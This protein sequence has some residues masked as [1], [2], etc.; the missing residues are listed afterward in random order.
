MAN[1]IVVPFLG[2]LQAA[3]TVLLTI[4]AGVLAAQMGL[5]NEQTSKQI[6][7]V[8]VQ[9]FLP[10]LL[11]SN[12][13]S[14]MHADTALYYVPIIIWAIVYNAVSILFG[15]AVQRLFKLPEWA[16]PAIAFN[17]TTALPLLLVQALD[18]TGILDSI[19]ASSGVV[20]RAKSF[21]LVNAMIG[22][23]LTFALGPKLLSGQN[24][25]APDGEGEGKFPTES[26]DDAIDRR[27][28]EQE[29][30]AVETNEQTSLLPGRIIR[31]L[32][33]AGYAGYGKSK[34]AWV[35]LPPWVQATLDFSSQ[36]FNAPLIG[37]AIGV[38]I[39][40]VPS[41]HR[42]FF[43]VGVKLSSSLLKMKK[44]EAGG[45]VPWS[46]IFVIL[47]TRFVLWPAIGI[48]VIYAVATRTGWLLD[49][50][51][52]WFC[53]MLMPTGPPALKLTALSDVNG[54]GEEEKMAIAKFL[55]VSYSVSPVIAFAVVGS[56]KAAQ[57]AAST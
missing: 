7:K 54:A 36:F 44:G 26:E 38:V 51:L 52:L 1:D 13:G 35:R 50:P 14:Q 4:G 5:L 46:A 22:N 11:I 37:A 55:M 32:T 48:P 6:S 27:V 19:D 16:T 25:D 23:S 17:N 12:V 24:E 20:D 34:K 21:F 30:E 56:L 9:L 33:R 15:I 45:H 28:E 42:L 3:I 41:L 57:A 29:D 47:T 31:P 40:I 53:M 39:G 18:A 43:V 10:A 2:A 8:C 49:D